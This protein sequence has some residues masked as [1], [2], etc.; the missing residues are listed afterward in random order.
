M[1]LSNAVMSQTSTQSPAIADGT[2]FFHVEQWAP[3][4][5]YHD[6]MASLLN[7]I[8]TKQFSPTKSVQQAVP[9]PVQRQRQAASKPKAVGRK[10]PSQPR[11][12]TSS[13]PP[14]G[15]RRKTK[16]NTSC[17][18]TPIP[19]VNRQRILDK[20]EMQALRHEL[21]HRRSYGTDTTA[22]S[23]MAA[24]DLH[25]AIESRDP[26]AV[27]AMLRSGVD[28]NL[29]RGGGVVMTSASGRP[30]TTSVVVTPLHRAFSVGC[31]EVAMLLVLAG[32]DLEA[33]N[34]AGETAVVRAVR[35]EFPDDFVALCCELGAAVDAPDRAGR[36]A[37]H[38]AA[39]LVHPDVSCATV[40]TLAAHGAHLDARD[41]DGR[42]PLHAAVAAGRAEVVRQLVAR[43][44]DVEAAL[45]GGATPLHLAVLRRNAQV[46]RVLCEHG[47]HVDGRP[48]I[49]GSC[50]SPGGGDFGGA[51]PKTPLLYA[52]ETG[53]TEIVRIL[54][55]HGAD[56]D[57]GS[58]G[59]GSAQ[60]CNLSS[61][62]TIITT[63][64]SKAGT[65]TPTSKRNSPSQP[66]SFPLLAAARLGN[67][68]VVDLLLA[69]G[70][71]LNQADAHRQT[72]LHAAAAHNHLDV[73][74]R[75]VA[76]GAAVRSL[77]DDGATPLLLAVRAGHEAVARHLLLGPVPAPAE[78]PVEREGVGGGS[79]A[80][81]PTA[82]WHAV[83]RGHHD[84]AK[85]LVVERGADPFRVVDAWGSTPLHHAARKG[86]DGLIELVLDRVV[87]GRGG[88]EH[89]G[90]AAVTDIG[91][92]SSSSS[93]SRT[94]F[95]LSS[96]NDTMT[97][98]A[99]PPTAQ[100]TTTP[101]PKQELD[102]EIWDTR[103]VKKATKE[104]AGTEKPVEPNPTNSKSTHA[105]E[106]QAS[107]LSASLL[108]AAA[109]GGQL[110]TLKLL[111][112]RRGTASAL[113]DLQSAQTAIGDGILAVA[114]AHPAVLRFLLGFKT[115][116]D[117]VGGGGGGSSSIWTAMIP[118]RPRRLLLDVNRG[119]RHG[120][121]ALHY[122]ALRGHVEG[123]RVLLQKGARQSVVTV[124]IYEGLDDYAERRD[125]KQ[126]T[127][128]GLARQKGFDTLAAMIDKWR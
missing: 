5:G 119:N 1:I 67:A 58:L 117:G 30:S 99:K 87:D 81:G 32:A 79:C 83:D 7:Y 93:S 8:Q 120:A 66:G 108:L 74:R 23:L 46:V 63:T 16:A 41:A 13:S 54:L 95:T 38:Y 9:P 48:G 100:E 68:A 127:P 107:K 43:G 24:R 113:A 49:G 97:A 114:T 106:A 92:A 31:L 57:L 88:G 109:E 69:Q 104:N 80:P 40:L 72:A 55:K 61:S 91:V 52:I 35:C 25:A 70:A 105:A 124:E 115:P 102:L 77:R 94:E 22:T 121:T 122:A 76:A 10:Q 33:T 60:V 20:P 65:S 44:A 21:N 4:H 73:V 3:S 89:P 29:S 84:M 18:R 15:P 116:D 11:L 125:Y 56:V 110:S 103:E 101:T 111:L 75:L 36:S 53:C 64:T 37:L 26:G 112:A 123:A 118:G 50:G 90:P 28:P 39:G 78:S 6:S 34:A 98:G 2:S 62:S 19:A 85:L 51:A 12:L 71:D 42:A 59:D 96:G 14:H 86:L 126:G 45:P 17:R 128:A 82:L 27:Y 47:V